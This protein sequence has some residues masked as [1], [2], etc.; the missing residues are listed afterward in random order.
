MTVMA[1]R[2]T[3]DT[4]DPPP[5]ADPARRP[6]LPPDPASYDAPRNVSARRKGLPTPY[7]AGGDDPD[8]A[9]TL[10]RESRDRRLLLWM[11]IAIVVGGFLLGIVF[12]LLGLGG[13]S[14]SGG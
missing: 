9:D 14:G 4:S 5:T 3:P 11:T 6:A 2:T 13:L 7:I 12:V 10:R 1:D 8:L